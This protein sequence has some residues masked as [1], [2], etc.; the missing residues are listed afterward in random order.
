MGHSIIEFRGKLLQLHDSE[1]EWIFEWLNEAR[2]EIGCEGSVRGLLDFCERE[3]S[4]MG[5]G[6][7]DP[8]LGAYVGD[9]AAVAEM[10]RL[11]D[12]VQ[13]RLS[14][15]GTKVPLAELR[16]SSSYPDAWQG[17]VRAD[18]Y[19]R[20]LHLFRSLIEGDLAELA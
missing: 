19:Q 4:D 15:C 12:A 16:R 2:R 13:K 8:P 5:N 20:A 7:L 1:I 9:D 10:S 14:A 6:C 11:L 17:D 18:I 3:L